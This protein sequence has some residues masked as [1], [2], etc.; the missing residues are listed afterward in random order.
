MRS[1]IFNCDILV[2]ID[3]LGYLAG[4]S[5]HDLYK[6][7]D[8]G[9]DS[10]ERGVP[11]LRE[12]CGDLSIKIPLS[13]PVIKYGHLHELGIPLL[14]PPDGQVA[15]DYTIHSLEEVQNLIASSGFLKELC[16]T[17]ELSRRQ[18]AYL[19]RLRTYFDSHVSWG[20]QWEGPLTT[21]WA[22][23]GENFFTA[24]YD[25]PDETLITLKSLAENIA[26]YIRM[27]AAID[28]IKPA[29]PFP[30]YGR[31]C[32]DLA[33]MVSPAIWDDY[34][35]IVWDICFREALPGRKVHCEGMVADHLLYLSRLGI[36]D[37]DPGISPK[38]NPDLIAKETPSVPFNWR[39]GSFHYPDMS[40][41]DV[42]Q[43][44]YHAAA[45]GSRSVFTIFEPIMCNPE[46]IEKISVFEKAAEKVSSL[47]RN[48]PA[49]TDRRELLSAV[50]E[51]SWDWGCW[52]GYTQ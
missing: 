31:L 36:H 16:F 35:G 49:D 20:W 17:Q 45:A 50:L 42:E 2:P 14:F 38:L 33:A 4:H 13:T 6:D 28:G 43:F 9:I 10:Y 15:P 18:I 51:D 34:V 30:D 40:C 27:Y 1:Q 22:L 37:Y 52:N 47:C 5:M 19:E 41:H 11:L 32:D 39:L 48:S 46:T 8:A 24:F 7:P 21:L 12:M 23:L 3:V 25:S 26:A 44:V 29:A